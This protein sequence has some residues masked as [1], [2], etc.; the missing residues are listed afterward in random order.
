[1]KVR[2]ISGTNCPTF[3]FTFTEQSQEMSSYIWD[4][5]PHYPE[6]L[7]W[8]VPKIPKKTNVPNCKIDPQ[9]YG[10]GEN[11]R[12]CGGLVSQT[13]GPKNT[14][15]GPQN[16]G[17]QMSFLTRCYAYETWF[18]SCG[19]WEVFI[20]RNALQK[21]KRTKKSAHRRKPK[22]IWHISAPLQTIGAALPEISL[23]WFITSQKKMSW[24]ASTLSGTHP[25][26]SNKWSWWGRNPA[27][28]QPNPVILRVPGP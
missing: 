23:A 17:T 22:D 26:S 12:I 10:G 11:L 16:I 3:F 18:T 2:K 21:C 8:M 7:N 19:T 13:R 4:G 27:R 14:K 25:V 9:F 15:K 24:N 1:M 5:D 6:T 20:Q 28:N